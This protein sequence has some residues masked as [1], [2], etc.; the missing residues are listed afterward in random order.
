MKINVLAYQRATRRMTEAGMLFVG[1]DLKHW[2]MRDT[3]YSLRNFP[4]SR[5]AIR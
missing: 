2:S 5:F 3:I 1:E 4:L